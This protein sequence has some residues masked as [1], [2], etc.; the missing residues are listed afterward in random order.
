MYNYRRESRGAIHAAF[1]APAWRFNAETMAHVKD[2]L[3]NTL[4]AGESTTPGNSGFRTF[5]A[6][7]YAYYTLSS[8]TAQ[9]RTLCGDYDQCVACDPSSSAP[10]KRGWGSSHG[11]IV[12]FVLCDG[13]VRPLST[14]IDMALFGNLATIDG[15]EIAT[16]PND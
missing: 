10:C 9:A 5:W 13:A 15:G 16:F 1:V 3:S 12:N 11:G 7:S 8:A 6:Y 2:G 14:S 4:L